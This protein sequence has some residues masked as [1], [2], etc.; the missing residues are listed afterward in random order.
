[1]SVWKRVSGGRPK[2]GGGVQPDLEGDPRVSLKKASHQ[3]SFVSHGQTFIS[4]L[5]DGSLVCS[6]NPVKEIPKEDAW[7]PW[8]DKP[9]DG[10]RSFEV[11]IIVDGVERIHQCTPVISKGYIEAK[12]SERAKR[13]RQIYIRWSDLPEWKQPEDLRFSLSRTLRLLGS[14]AIKSAK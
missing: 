1:M 6:V 11:S 14:K 9:Y 13:G 8:D 2:G 4:G 10:S 12:N 7:S 3:Q 5:P